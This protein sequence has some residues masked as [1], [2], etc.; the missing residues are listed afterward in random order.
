MKKPSDDIFLLIK[1]LSPSE[2]RYFRT[3]AGI[4]SGGANNAYYKLFMAIDAQEE[5]DEQAL[6]KKHSKQK[7]AKNLPM[8]KQY[9]QNLLLKNL[10]AYHAANNTYKEI[11][12]KIDAA[13]ILHGKGLFAM[14]KKLLSTARKQAEQHEYFYLAALALRHEILNITPQTTSN[15]EAE[16]RHLHGKL[17]SLLDILQREREYLLLQGLTLSSFLSTTYLRDDT[18]L[19]HEILRHPLLQENSKPDEAVLRIKYHNTLSRCHFIMGDYHNA[20]RHAKAEIETFEELPTRMHESQLYYLAQLHNFFSRSLKAQRYEELY[21]II[22]KIRSV[23]STNLQVQKFKYESL[24]SLEITYYHLA[25]EFDRAMALTQEIEQAD[26]LLHDKVR[27]QHRIALFFNVMATHIYAGDYTTALVYANRIINHPPVLQQSYSISKILA[28][29]IHSELGNQDILDSVIRSAYRHLQK[30][31]HLFAMERIIL[32][33][34]RKLGNIVDNA[35]LQQFLQQLR[36]ELSA[37]AHDPKEARVLE[38]FHFIRWIDAKIAN[39]TVA[40]LWKPAIQH[41]ADNPH[42]HSVVAV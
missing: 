24:F 41:T 9:L 13:N 34:F 11:N 29:V 21:P 14:S 37:A 36:T 27:Q 8:A 16:V 39:T 7:F 35:T 6:L 19:L 18:T 12:E 26:A 17:G 32:R 25:G 40:A 38:H 15:H 33:S 1:S 4:K 5:Y 10:C 28:I 3:M 31:G 2:K 22:Q 30:Q 23:P 42:H 20:Y